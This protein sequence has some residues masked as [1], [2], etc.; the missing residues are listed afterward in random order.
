MIAALV[1]P[2]PKL[3]LSAWRMGTFMRG[4]RTMS[5]QA[6][7]SSISSA[8]TDGLTNE[9][10]IICVQKISSIAPAAPIG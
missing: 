10:S 8:F 3:L 1:P 9:C 5:A 2:N 7:D 4:V 6:M